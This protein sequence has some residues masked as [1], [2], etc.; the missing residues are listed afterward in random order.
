MEPRSG[1]VHFCRYFM[2]IYDAGFK[3][4][5]TG[6]YSKFSRNQ[7]HLSTFPSAA[8][9]SNN[10]PLALYLPEQQGIMPAQITRG[11]L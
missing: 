3:Y 10:H 5:H 7:G 8:V 9:V 6:G 1:G 11:A 4:R 2:L